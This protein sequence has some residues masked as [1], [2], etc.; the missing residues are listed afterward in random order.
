MR[1]HLGSWLLPVGFNPLS[2][3]PLLLL[4]HRLT[5]LSPSEDV[6]DVERVARE[7]HILKLAGCPPGGVFW[8][9]EVSRRQCGRSG[10]L[11]TLSRGGGWKGIWSILG[12]EH[13]GP[14]TTIFWVKTASL[15]DCGSTARVRCGRFIVRCNIPTSFSSTTSLRRRDSCA[16][17]RVGKR[18]GKV[19]WSSHPEVFFE[20]G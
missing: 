15:T 1:V 4:L 14:K 12:C 10:A 6:A 17:V 9:E 3:Y 8:D 2:S 19:S 11:V 13:P 18:Y 20:G 16:L 5:P 7:I